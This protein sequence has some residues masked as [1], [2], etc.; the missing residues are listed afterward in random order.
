M[1]AIGPMQR[2]TRFALICVP[3][4]PFAALLLLAPLNRSCV[5]EATLRAPVKV[6][7]YFW[8][9]RYSSSEFLLCSGHGVPVTSAAPA[10]F[11][12]GQTS[13]GTPVS[14]FDEMA[15]GHFINPWIQRPAPLAFGPWHPLTPEEFVKFQATQARFPSSSR[16]TSFRWH[17]IAQQ[18]Q[19]IGQERWTTTVFPTWLLYAIAL[20]P[21]ALPLTVFVRWQLRRRQLG[22]TRED[23]SVS[24]PVCRYDLRA[25]PCRC[26][27]CGWRRAEG[28]RRQGKVRKRK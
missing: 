21:A 19:Q 17:G 1:K 14:L 6:A 2:L 5:V 11:T 13:D 18:T 24:C 8:G 25:T 22:T 3:L 26:P 15:R 4:V 23:G 12:L 20:V 7:G 9:V 10:G 16:A 27:E 28:A